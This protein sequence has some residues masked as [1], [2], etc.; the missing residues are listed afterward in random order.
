MEAVNAIG[1]DLGGTNIKA[2]LIDAQG[3]LL[4]HDKIPTGSDQGAEYVLAQTA[5][6]VK[7]LA[8]QHA[9]GQRE[10][11]LGVAIP[12]EVN[13]AG[14]VWRLPN[15]AGFEGV[16]FAKALREKLAPELNPT[17]IAI[18]N[19]AICAAWGEYQ[20]GVSKTYANQ[21]HI[22]LGT[23]VGG[24]LVLGGKLYRG[25]DGF[26]AEIGHVATHHDGRPCV[27]GATGCMEAYTCARGILQTHTELGGDGIESV[28]MLVELAAADD[29][30]ALA[31][32]EQA[33]GEL[34][35]GLASMINVLNLDALVFSGGIRGALPF[36]LPSIQAKLRERCMG[37][38]AAELPLLTTSL[39]DDAGTIGAALLALHP[40]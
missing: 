19:D 5:L 13:D 22:T 17:H 37:K 7:R 36:M 3:K 20:A 28:A 6:V 25:R 23:G 21:L 24:G 39:G 26:A 32:L 11:A 1:V 38:V 27:C 14:A 12:G 30:I 34:G 29:Q 16:V 8:K 31:T 4:A 15:I 35:H 33:G 10:I 9:S 2:A 18:D 40:Q